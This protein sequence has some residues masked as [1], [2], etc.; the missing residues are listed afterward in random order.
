MKDVAY[1]SGFGGYLIS[2]NHK[3]DTGLQHKGVTEK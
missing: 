1:V 2:K 3:N